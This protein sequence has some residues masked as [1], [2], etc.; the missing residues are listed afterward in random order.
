MRLKV[1][2]QFEI[3]PLNPNSGYGRVV[4]PIHV[5]GATTFTAAIDMV[6]NKRWGLETILGQKVCVNSIELEEGE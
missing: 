4:I 3:N 5:D 6:E 2:C 1:L